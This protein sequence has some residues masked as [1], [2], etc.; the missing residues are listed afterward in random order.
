VLRGLERER[1]RRFQSMASLI[2][3]LV[4]SPRRSPR[5]AAV[6]VG[7]VLLVGGGTTAFVARQHPPPQPPPIAADVVQL[8]EELRE[9]EDQRQALLT[10]LTQARAD[11]AELAVVRAALQKKDDEIRDLIDKV[12][13]LQSANT[14]LLDAAKRSVRLAAASRQTLLAIDALN[15]V[16][17]PIEGCFREWAERN[18]VTHDEVSEATLIVGLTVT[19]GGIGAMGDIV[20]TPDE[21][22]SG[23]DSAR[24]RSLLEMCV[25]EQIARVHFPPGPDRLELEA[26]AQWSP[27]QVKLSAKLLDRRTVPR[28]QIELP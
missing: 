26:M 27:G 17:R 25:S 23:P 14:R 15:T 19:P 12:A 4:P 9:K 20:S 18:E 22:V 24:G 21:H 8:G 10:A 3:E 11:Q 16:Q 13:Q 6:A 5:Y 28:G 1:A 2:D 7:A